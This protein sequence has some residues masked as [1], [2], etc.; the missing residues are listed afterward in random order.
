MPTALRVGREYFI[1]APWKP[2]ADGTILFAN[3]LEEGV[4][5]ELVRLTDIAASTRRFFES[6]LPSRVPSPR[7]ALL[8][9]CSGR[10]WFAEGRGRPDAR[11]K[12][13]PAA[14][15]CAGLNVH[16]EIYCGF[17]INTT[18]TA[19]AFGATP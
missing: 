15:P 14:P 7:A 4:E 12:A 2:L 17:H 9:H 18:L 6:E 3:M 11:S 10:K 5:L 1:R 16:F 13:F 19:L 8:F